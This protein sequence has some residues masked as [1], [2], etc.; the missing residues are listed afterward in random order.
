[1]KSIAFFRDIFINMLMNDKYKEAKEFL[2]LHE[3]AVTDIDEIFRSF[4]CDRSN[5]L[6]QF[7]KK[8][9]NC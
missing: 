1:M 4:N 6:S 9:N 5:M 3:M 7:K 8:L 2:S